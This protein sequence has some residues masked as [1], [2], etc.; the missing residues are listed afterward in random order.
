MTTS[1]TNLSDLAARNRRWVTADTPPIKSM[2]GF[3]SIGMPRGVEK[4]IT[5]KEKIVEKWKIS[6]S[7]IRCICHDD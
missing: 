3:C 4:K 2:K 5:E 7:R 1:D 6:N